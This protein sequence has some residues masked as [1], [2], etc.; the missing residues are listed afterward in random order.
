MVMRVAS[1]FPFRST[2]YLKKPGDV[3]A[4]V[5]QGHQLLAIGQRDSDRR[6]CATRTS[7]IA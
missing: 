6:S 2:Y 7:G 3:V 4:V 5:A 1:F